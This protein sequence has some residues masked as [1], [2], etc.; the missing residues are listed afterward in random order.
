MRAIRF[1]VTI[2]GLLLAAGALTLATVPRMNGRLLFRRLLVHPIPRSVQHI[3]TD[4]CQISS[5]VDRLDGFREHAFVL[6]FE[7][8]REDLSRIIAARGFKRWEDAKYSEGILRYKS[9][10]QFLTSIKLY[11]MRRQPPNW[12]DLE[13]WTKFETYFVGKDE[14]GLWTVDVS[15]L[16][17]DEQRGCAY[18]I[19][20]DMTGL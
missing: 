10:D 17:Y 9:S 1:I 19:K 12:F 20:W 2:L 8:N 6:R 11:N 3:K 15:L 7:V 5:L 14:T 16:L 4:S 13:Q 18:V